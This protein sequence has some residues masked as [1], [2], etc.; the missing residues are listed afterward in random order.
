MVSMCFSSACGV[1]ASLLRLKKV[2]MGTE[3]GEYR[4]AVRSLEDGGG[5]NV[6]SL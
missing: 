5:E 4:V 3:E 6:G 1:S 2:E